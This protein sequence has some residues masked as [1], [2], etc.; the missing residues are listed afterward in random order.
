MELDQIGPNGPNSIEM[1][2]LDQ[3]ELYGLKWTKVDRSRLKC[4][5]DVAQYIGA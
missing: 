2:K 5:T 4:F 3:T 1:A